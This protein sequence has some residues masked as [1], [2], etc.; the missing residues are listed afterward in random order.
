MPDFVPGIELCGAF[1]AQV[2]RPALAVAFPDLRYS[3]ALL[4]TGS[5]VLGFD[6][7]RSTDTD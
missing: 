2:V 6:T 5:E 7:E 4:G 3:A 1:Y